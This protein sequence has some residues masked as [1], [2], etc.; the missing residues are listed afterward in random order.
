MITSLKKRDEERM[1]KNVENLVDDLKR[2]AEEVKVEAVKEEDVK[3]AEEEKEKKD[4][5]DG[6]EVV[7]KEQLNEE[8]MKKKGEADVKI[9]STIEKDSAGV[10]EE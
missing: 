3:I 1:K 7:S 2:V 4:D 5:A 10:G 9:E 6:E 8:V